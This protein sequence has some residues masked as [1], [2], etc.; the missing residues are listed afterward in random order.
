M[1]TLSIFLMD[2]QCLNTLNMNS[3]Y[4]SCVLFPK[5]CKCARACV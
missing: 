4:E 2:L 1:K 5:F 3:S